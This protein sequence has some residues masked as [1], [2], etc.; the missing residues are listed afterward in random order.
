MAPLPAA[1][2]EVLTARGYIDGLGPDA[3]TAPRFASTLIQKVAL[4]DRFSLIEGHEW[5]VVRI[6]EL[7]PFWMA[8]WD[9]ST[10]AVSDPTEVRYVA[11]VF[12]EVVEARRFMARLRRR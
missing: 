10:L 12:E 4:V 7:G 5:D 11:R 8:R 6:P 2:T 3:F 9:R 1:A